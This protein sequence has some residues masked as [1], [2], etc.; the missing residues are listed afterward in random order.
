VSNS[1]KYA[2]SGREKGEIRIRL[3]RDE[4]Q[5]SEDEI[6]GCRDEGYIDEEL[7]GSGEKRYT[8]IVSDN[9]IG[10]PENISLEDSDTLGVQLVTI[11]VDQ[12]DGEIKLNR[13][14]GTEFTIEIPVT[15]EA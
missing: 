11:L 3:Y 5:G 13:D 1:L 14:S 8:L 15:E 12:L 10:I 6:S 9:G 2:F 4:N 7:A